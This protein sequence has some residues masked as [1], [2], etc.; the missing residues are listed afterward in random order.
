MRKSFLVLFLVLL[1]SACLSGARTYNLPSN[2]SEN[3]EF[4]I[5]TCSPGKE[6]YSLFGHTAI[7]LHDPASRTDIVFNY[8]TFDFN[9]DRFYFKFAKGILPYQLSISSYYGFLMAYK[10]EGRSIYSQRLNL[11]YGAKAELYALLAENYKPENRT[12]QYDF[13]YDNCSSRVRDIVVRAVGGN[14]RFFDEDSGDPL[15]EGLFPLD[16]KSYWDMLDEYIGNHAWVHWGI[17][18]ILGYPASGKTDVFSSM[19][20]PDYL[21]AAFSTARYAAGCG[22]AGEES[23]ELAGG[24]GQDLE[25]TETCSGNDGYMPLVF[26]YVVEHYA[27]N[28]VKK[29]P[30]LFSPAFV[31]L[32]TAIVAFLLLFVLRI[33]Y[34][35]W[36]RKAVV[37]FFFAVTG[38]I[39]CLLVFLGF[40]TLHPTTAPNFN[41]VWANPLNLIAL[42]FLFTK[43]A[44]IASFMKWYMIAY[45][46]VLA[47]AFVLWPFAGPSVAVSNMSWIAI[48]FMSALA[49]KL[50]V[51]K[52]ARRSR[53]LRD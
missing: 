52:V 25:K 42:F 15:F 38:L 32:L 27:E 24:H 2:I 3:A 13:L 53:M 20:L 40:F 44:R 14:V 11:D 47:A 33:R 45:M 10:E 21:M 29:T 8:G 34:V 5:L 1:S 26:P 12:Y 50:E 51:S 43:S 41:M 6:V 9:T 23:R 30:F 7:R 19:F 46:A 39:G 28:A 49:C 18:T 36:F 16:G 17:H 4:H 35:S 37:V 31:F 48:S 22:N